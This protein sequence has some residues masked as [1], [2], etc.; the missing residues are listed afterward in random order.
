MPLSR[1]GQVTPARQPLYASTHYR[2]AEHPEGQ[3]AHP[4]PA[5]APPPEVP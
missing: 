2:H 4:V 3:L 5:Q 1:R